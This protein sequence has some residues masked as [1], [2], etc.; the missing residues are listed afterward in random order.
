MVFKKWFSEEIMSA[1]CWVKDVSQTPALDQKSFNA[2]RKGIKLGSHK[3]FCVP[4]HTDLITA[5]RDL[6]PGYQLSIKLTRMQDD[7]V[8]W[9]PITNKGTAAGAQPYEYEI[10]IKDLRLSV[11]KVKV[12]DR[13]FNHYYNGRNGR[14]PEIP[15]TRNMLRSYT[16]S[17]NIID[18]GSSNFVEQR[19]LPE[20]VYVV[21][22][23][24]DAYN[25]KRSENP[26][27][28]KYI[29]LL[30]ASLIVNGRLGKKKN[31]DK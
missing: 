9:S 25:G 17:D 4:L 13:I 21:F 1:D 22:I 18:L 28:F 14:I 5:T 26:F 27:N 11:Q 7:F 23:E 10:R 12:D 31:N 30:E 20:A 15:F 2:R 16:K 6:P 24:Q 8:V 29:P 19:Q 3:E